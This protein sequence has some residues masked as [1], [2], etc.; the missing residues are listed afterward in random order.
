MDVKLLHRLTLVM[1]QG[2]TCGTSRKTQ[3]SSLT[4]ALARMTWN[5]Q[6]T[7]KWFPLKSWFN[8]ITG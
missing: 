5:L 2:C 7:W 3:Y 4:S 1:T 6:L 8:V